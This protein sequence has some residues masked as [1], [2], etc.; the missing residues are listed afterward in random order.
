MRSQRKSLG[1]LYSR[2]KFVVRS[3]ADGVGRAEHHMTRKWIA[4]KHPVERA[5]DLFF[6]NLPCDQRAL[7]QIRCQQSLPDAPDRSRAQH[8]G[9][10]RHHNLDSYTR[11]IG[12]FLER[13][14][15]KSFDLVSEIARI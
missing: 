14:T 4:P 12:N 9:D 13:F 11:A 3:S 7:G 10:A 1:S 6:R 5:V 8:R 15:D 2:P